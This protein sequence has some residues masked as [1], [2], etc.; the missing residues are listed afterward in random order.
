MTTPEPQP[1]RF[2]AVVRG[3]AQELELSR[4][5]ALDLDRVPDPGD[6]VRLLVSAEDI[7]RLLA[8]GYEVRLQQVVPVQPLDPALVLS[9]ADAEAWF[10][11]QV[12]E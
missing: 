12:G 8:E 10:E 4:I 2:E 9:D 3:R 1:V 6:E 5:D 11:T 7:P